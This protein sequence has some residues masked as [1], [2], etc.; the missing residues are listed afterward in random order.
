MQKGRLSLLRTDISV[1]VRKGKCK[2]V[3]K[4]INKNGDQ[5]SREKGRLSMLMRGKDILFIAVFI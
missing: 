3:N 2:Y 1:H 5:C 4:Q